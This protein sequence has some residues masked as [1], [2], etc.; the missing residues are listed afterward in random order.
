MKQFADHGYEIVPFDEPADVYIINTCSV[1]SIADRKSRQMLH[2]A[3]KLCPEALVVAVGCYV[4]ADPERALSDEAVDLVIGNDQK[5]KAFEIIESRLDVCTDISKSMEFDDMCIIS[6]RSTRAFIKIQDGCNQFCSYC[7]IPYLRGRIRSR[8]KESILSEVKTLYNEG[9]REV[10]LTGIH[11]SSYGLKANDKFDG[12]NYHALLDIIKEVAA[13]MEGGRVRL[14][15]LE[16]RII[17]PDF[18]REISS[19]DNLCPHFHLSLQSGCDETLKRMNR[20]YTTEQYKDA[21]CLLREFYDH[22]AITTD[23]IVGFPGESDE[24][25]SITREFLE[26]INLY[27]MHIFKYSVRE[28]TNAASL[29]G[30]IAPDIQ[31]ERSNILLEM[32]ERHR[33]LF[34]DYYKGKD[35]SVLIEEE[36]PSGLVGFTPEYI[37]VT[38]EKSAGAIG[39][40][41][42]HTIN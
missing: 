25:F 41:V 3:K 13:I 33:A 21:V 31:E 35:V 17:T 32:S 15:S 30:R 5:S 10:V 26:D 22:P 2:R 36:T 20:H 23:V 42:N 11:L 14:G 9:C 34:T 19:I 12:T 27:E 8:S 18:V 24:E 7:L 39:N 29:P 1:T 6:P 4:Q 16:P 38:L 40:I 28:G 37:K